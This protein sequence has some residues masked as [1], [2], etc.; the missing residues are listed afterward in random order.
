MASRLPPLPTSEPALAPHR[1]EPTP[2][3][4]LALVP[5]KPM[6]NAAG[7]PARPAAQ[8]EQVPESMPQPRRCPECSRAELQPGNYQP[9]RPQ[10][11]I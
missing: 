4:L 5:M 7:V 6:P 11:P 1:S 3:P 10:H 2:T 9:P 8:I